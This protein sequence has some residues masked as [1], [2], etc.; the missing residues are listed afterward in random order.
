M[1]DDAELARS[2]WSGIPALARDPAELTDVEAV[3]MA[4]DA[5]GQETPIPSFSSAGRLDDGHPAGRADSS[6]STRSWSKTGA[7]WGQPRWPSHRFEA[8]YAD[9]SEYLLGRADA[10]RTRSWTRTRSTG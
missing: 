4:W 5:S 2:A 6:D 1:Y 7:G 9:A 10:R 8:E 3:A